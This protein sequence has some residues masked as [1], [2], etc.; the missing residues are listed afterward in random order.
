MGHDEHR[1]R[2]SPSSWQ[3]VA[4]RQRQMYRRAWDSLVVEVVV[5]VVYL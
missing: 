1:L 3:A 4:Q 2:P 5:P